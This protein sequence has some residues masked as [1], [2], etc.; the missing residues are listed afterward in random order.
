MSAVLDVKIQKTESGEIRRGV[1][2]SEFKRFIAARGDCLPRVVYSNGVLETFMPGTK[3]ESTNYVLEKLVGY[4]ADESEI[5][6]FGVGALLFE[7]DKVKQGVE[8]DS[9]FYFES[10]NLIADVDEI[11]LNRDPA[12]DLVIEVDI[13]SPSTRRFPIFAVYGVPEVWRYQKKT[14]SVVFFKLGNGR[15]TE[16]ENS[17]ALPILSSAK[18]TEFLRRS[19]ET[20]SSAWAKQVREWTR[21]QIEMAEG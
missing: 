10:Q 9:C 4:I 5:D 21:E 11:D 15:Y 18:A 12:P 19:R 8:P 6:L 1:D 3:H 2:W 20:K 16:I 7:S 13:T 14:D 17:L